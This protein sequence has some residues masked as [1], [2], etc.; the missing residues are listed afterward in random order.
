MQAY[1]IGLVLKDK[2]GAFVVARTLP[3]TTQPPQ[4]NLKS[5]FLRPRL[6]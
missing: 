1:A 3:V 6:A 2:D 4:N 5:H